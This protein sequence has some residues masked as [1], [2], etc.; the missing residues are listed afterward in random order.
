MTAVEYR[1]LSERNGLWDRLERAHRPFSYLHAYDHGAS[2]N[3]AAIFGPR[4]LLRCLPLQHH[5]PATEGY[6]ERRSEAAVAELRAQIEGLGEEMMLLA[7]E[8]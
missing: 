4:L 3:V 8:V 1:G 5:D 2:R 6:S 7:D